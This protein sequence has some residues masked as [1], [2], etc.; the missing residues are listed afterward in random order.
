MSVNIHILKAGSD[1]DQYEDLIRNEIE[2]TIDKVSSFTDL[3]SIDI[4][5]D[6]NADSTI[7]EIGVGGMAPNANL[8]YIH[9]DTSFAH[10]EESLAREIRSTTAHEVHHCIRSDS[11]GYG[12][13]LLEAMVSEG[14]ADHFDIEL[15]GGDPKK[16]D[17]ALDEDQI[18]SLLD[19]AKDDFY[20][21][22]YD[23]SKWFFGGDEIPRWTGYTLGFKLVR[24]YMES[25]NKKASELIHTPAEEFLNVL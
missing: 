21:E 4:V 24:D 25:N 11:V 18:G 8:H 22:K 1:L 7:P 9:I 6:N 3:P 2:N 19:K 15:N 5:V 23:H 14:L 17:V 10:T 12:K 13:T 20:N 16:W